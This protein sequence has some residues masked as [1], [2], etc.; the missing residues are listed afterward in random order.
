VQVRHA[1]DPI[2]AAIN[3]SGIPGSVN[4]GMNSTEERIAGFTF[5]II[6]LSILIL[7]VYKFKTACP[8]YFRDDTYE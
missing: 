1:G 6:F 4:F 3:L 8:D 5:L 2:L 7:I